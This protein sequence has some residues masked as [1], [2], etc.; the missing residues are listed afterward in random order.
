MTHEAFLLKVNLGHEVTEF[1][2]AV[3]SVVISSQ[4]FRQLI[5]EKNEKINK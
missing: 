5:S 4:L 3:N 2:A 1:S